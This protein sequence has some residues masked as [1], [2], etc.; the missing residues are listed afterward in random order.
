MILA[1][2]GHRPQRLKGQ[3]KLIKEWAVEQL[4]RLQPSVIYDGMAQGADQIIATAAKELGIPIGCCYP[5]PKKYYHPVEQWIAEN[6][7]VIFVSPQYSKDAYNIRDKFMVD[8]ADK[9]LCVWDGI[10]WGGTFLTRNYALQQGKEI[11]D[12]GGLMA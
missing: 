9:L 5:F 6:N 2:T 8:H 12:Y 4:T 3:E 10:G 11:I 1:I 7:Q